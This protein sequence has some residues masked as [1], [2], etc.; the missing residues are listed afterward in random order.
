MV[1]TGLL[2]GKV[3]DTQELFFEN[4]SL[5]MAK[6]K[7]KFAGKLIFI[8][9]YTTWCAPCKQ[10][11]NETLSKPAVL[12]VMSENFISIKKDM[13]T[14]E[15]ALIASRYGV[16]EYPSYLFLT[17]E[18]RLVYSLVGFL[19][20]EK[21]LERIRVMV[22]D[23][24][25]CYTGYSTGEIDFPG[26]Y[27]D[28]HQ[29]K[30]RRIVPVVRNYFTANQDLLLEKNWLIAKTFS[31]QLPEA[32]IQWALDHFAALSVK[33]GAPDA[34]AL[35]ERYVASKM[36]KAISG[37]NAAQYANVL[38]E[39]RMINISIGAYNADNER[40]E[41]LYWTDFYGMNNRWEEYIVQ[42]GAYRER[43]GT[44][45]DVLFCRQITESDDLPAN[46]VAGIWLA[47]VLK[48][49]SGFYSLFCNFRVLAKTGRDQ[50]ALVYL[51]RAIQLAA[52]ASHAFDDYLLNHTYKEL[53]KSTADESKLAFIEKEVIYKL[54]DARKASFTAALLYLRFYTVNHMYGRLYETID[55]NWEIY[56]S[57]KGLYGF[58]KQ[59][60]PSLKKHFGND[61]TVLSKLQAWEKALS[62]K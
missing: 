61:E 43:F 39:K 12:K 11:D 24:S 25:S 38:A 21:F 51:T 2:L 41:L 9:C 58:L 4:T 40:Q 44:D 5:A 7:A 60:L 20:E 49:D 59:V 34:K 62:P 35:V 27:K 19:P 42:A 56:S 3:A 22:T 52:N 29:E 16:N 57:D 55:R 30:M 33:Y 23:R 45:N 53:V 32:Q 18:G 26:F 1:F 46:R 36:N 8:D 10:M 47:D 17:A 6:E 13:E 15:G 37:N 31:R 50:E 14:V 28:Y 48:K 54:H